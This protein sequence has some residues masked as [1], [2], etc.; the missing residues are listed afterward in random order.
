MNIPHNVNGAFVSQDAPSSLPPGVINSI[1]D[2]KHFATREYGK[3][4]NEMKK[5]N[6]EKVI[7]TLASLM[8]SL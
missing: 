1:N 2:I 8:I 4:S 6:Q 3:R 7:N 5:E